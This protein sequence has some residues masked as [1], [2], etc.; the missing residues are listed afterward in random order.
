MDAHVPEIKMNTPYVVAINAVSGGGKT[1]LTKRVADALGSS[2]AFYF[3][4]FDSTNTY[5]EDYYEWS[6]RGADFEEFDC[7][8]MQQAV[9]GAIGESR[10]DYIVLDYPFGRDHSRF[11]DL[12][13]LSVFVDTPLD[14]AMARRIIRDFI[15]ISEEAPGSRLRKLRDDLSYYVDKARYPY[16]DTYRHKASSDLILDG[17]QSLDKLTKQVIE[18]IGLEQSSSTNSGNAPLR[19]ASPE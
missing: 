17:W 6:M 15:D 13:S 5:P 12:I 11:E 7:P 16:L 2:Q 3:D 19:S 18:R 10:V 1:T 4:E 9:L 14:I 8:G